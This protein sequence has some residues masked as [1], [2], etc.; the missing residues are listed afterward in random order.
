LCTAREASE[1]RSITP[2]DTT[3]KSRDTTGESS[4]VFSRGKF[5]ICSF[6]SPYYMVAQANKT[7]TSKNMTN[8]KEKK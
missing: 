5:C 7:R 3:G 8:E 6:F 2:T 4:D 1:I